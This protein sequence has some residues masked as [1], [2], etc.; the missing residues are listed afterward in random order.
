MGNN[1]RKC[2]DLLVRRCIRTMVWHEIVCAVEADDEDGD[3]KD[4]E[5]E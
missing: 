3:G 5:D 4:D 2:I 1:T